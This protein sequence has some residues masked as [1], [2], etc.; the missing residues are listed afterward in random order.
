MIKE[1]DF[2]TFLYISNYQ[3]IIF[4]DDK[5]NSKNL[6]KQEFNIFACYAI[7]YNHESTL[8]KKSQIV[9]KWL[10]SVEKDYLSGKINFHGENSAGED[11]TYAQIFTSILDGSGS[12]NLI[13]IVPSSSNLIL[14]Y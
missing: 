13:K 2:E 7:L 3:Y 8:R 1:S 11:T 6:Y 9:N 10:K 14:L 5:K 12:Y 4:V